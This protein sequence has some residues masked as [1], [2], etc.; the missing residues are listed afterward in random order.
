MFQREQKIG[1]YTLV[2]R[3]G[4]GGFGEVWLADRHGKFAT[5]QVAVKLPLDEQVDHAAIEQEA[6]LWAKASGHPN[7]LPIIEAD[8]YDGQ[9]VIVSEY[10]PDGSLEQWLRQNGKMPFE[11][12]VQTTIQILDG[13]EFLHSRNII[14]RDLKPA[15]ILLQG[16]TP[17]LADFGISRALKTTVASQSQNISGTFSYMSPE[18]L[19]GKRSMQTDIWSVGVNLYQLLTGTLPFPHTE[20]SVLITSIMLRE[21]EPFPEFIPNSLKEIITK[22]LQKLPENRY[23]T[24][25]EMREDLRKALVNI[26]H[27]T[28]APTEILPAPTVLAL[29]NSEPTLQKDFFDA[30]TDSDRSVVTKISDVPKTIP[31]FSTD[32]ELFSSQMQTRNSPSVPKIIAGVFAVFL[33]AVSIIGFLLYLA[34]SGTNKAQNSNVSNTSKNYDAV[35]DLEDATTLAKLRTEGLTVVNNPN[36]S[37]CNENQLEVPKM[38]LQG[39]PIKEKGIGSGDTIDVRKERIGNVS[40]ARSESEKPNP[41]QLILEIKSNGDLYLNCQM[42]GNAL[43]QNTVLEDLRKIF[44]AREENGVFREA[45]NI[46]EKTATIQSPSKIDRDIFFKTFEAVKNSGASPIYLFVIK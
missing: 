34:I 39:S 45:T 19:D 43:T 22:S 17:R 4:R 8:E 13:L 12:A 42:M 23:G 40:G 20:P 26:Q 7:V 25:G 32:D 44:K 16:T 30:D 10:A 27:P 21:F 14:H 18:A 15:N 5:T 33:I 9:I 37:R 35:L 2:K 1:V 3:L 24:A 38:F 11:K 36:P 28:F 29:Q 6:Q 46:I 41:L 31:Q